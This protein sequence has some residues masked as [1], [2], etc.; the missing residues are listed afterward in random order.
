VPGNDLD[1]HLV[2][3]ASAGTGKTYAIEQLVLR[4][5]TEKGLRL[6][7]ILVVTYTEKATGDLKG[8]L[9]SRLEDT[10]R[11]DSEHRIRLQEALDDF[12]QAHVYTIHGFCQR[13]LQE[14][15]FENRHAFRPQLV[16]DP[17]LLEGCLHEIQ[18]KGWC[19][20]YGA[21]LA[22]VL[23][24]SGY[25]SGRDRAEEWEERA[26]RVAERYRPAAKHMLLPE[27][28]ATW[29]AVLEK[30]DADLR[31]F[32]RQLLQW[33]GPV[34]PHQIEAHPW[35]VGFGRLPGPYTEA[36]RDNVLAHLL[37][38][39]ADPA[40][41]E[42]PLVTFRQ[43]LRRCG[44]FGSFGTNG[45]E[46]L[47]RKMTKDAQAQ[48]PK[49]CPQ[50]REA[51]DELERR[52]GDVDWSVLEQQLAVQT[53]KRLQEQLAAVK[54][55]RGQQSFEDMLT[56]VDQALAPEDARAIALRDVLRK[57]FRYAVVDEFQDTDPVQWNI[58]RRLFV[59]NA[60]DNRLVVVGD[61]KQAIFGF[62][63]ADVEAYLAARD[64]LRDR[65]GA[66]AVLQDTNWRSCSEMLGA[67]NRLFGE[68][69]WFKGSRIEYLAVRPP[70]D[71]PPHRLVTDQTDRPALSLVD[72][73]GPRKLSAARKVYARFVAQEIDR[74]LKAD[75]PTLRIEIKKKP[76]SLR[77]DD[78]CVLVFK[79]PEARPLL[80]ALQAR[81][82]PYT[83][84]K[85]PGLWQSDEAVHLRYLLRAVAHP[86]DRRAFHTALLTRFFR[87][88]PQQL[89]TADE[90]P[91]DHPARELFQRWYGLAEKRQ[92]AELFQ[93]FLEQTGVLFPEAETCDTDRSLA[94]FRHLLQTLEQ[95]AYGR[96][97]DM[98]GVLETFEQ[99]QRGP[100]QADA[101]LKPIE[102]DR[103][104]VK[105]M[106]IHASKGLEF[107]IVFL[108]GGFTSGKLPDVLTYRDDEHKLVFD[109]SCNDGAKD[110]HKEEQDKEDRRLLYVALTRAMFKLYVPRVLAK[111]ERTAGREVRKYS[112]AGPVVEILAPAVVASHLEE[113]GNPH[114]AR[115]AVTPDVPRPATS[116]RRAEEEPRASHLG[117]GSC[118]HASID[119]T[120]APVNLATDLFPVIDVSR[121]RG[122]DISSFSR[123]HR[124][125]AAE[126]P[127]YL[128]RPPRGDDD[129][130]D[131]L[132]KPDTLGGPVFG[133]MVHDVLA[134]I[135]FA[136]VGWARDAADL[137]R[138]RTPAQEL[139]DQVVNRHLP[140]LFSRLPEEQLRK[141]C[142]EQVASLVW[143]GLHTP[144][145]ELGGPLWPIPKTDRLHEL[146][147]HFP[148]QDAASPD[149][150]REDLYLT[151]FMD[152]VFRAGGRY[153]LLDWKTN[154]LPAGYARAEIERSMREC[155]YV[156]QCRLYVQA[157][158]RW[159]KW[160]QGPRFDF[161][162]D[163]G[164]A[165]YLYLRGINA[166]DGGGVFF[167]R[168]TAEDLRL[169]SVL[170]DVTEP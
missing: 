78:I 120:Q 3:E 16:S 67:L 39:L 143:S 27:L 95:A 40:A 9:R 65:S 66:R 88:R 32:V 38:W 135:D 51:V 41:E 130:P 23:E 113:M 37:A 169:E 152:L 166:R 46:L 114:V 62:C 140:R 92:W 48:L 85:E 111:D 2:I 132:E 164:G 76:R 117:N 56:R 157:L 98:L 14:Y 79:R 129:R 159:L 94:N 15:A 163:F 127:S 105:I 10:L 59:E 72:L 50:L 167:H 121:Q 148:C 156:R 31:A 28:M 150:R 64:E 168:P 71:D 103:P 147:F 119:P 7:Q 42:R 55:E 124:R 49:C 86:G 108:A 25:N 29:P 52:R 153:F 146:E 44:E 12:D 70:E 82:I 8:R 36:R 165:Y 53:V 22:T 33:A 131:A 81:D 96:D 84:Y 136:L 80:E 91:P 68:S 104:K 102:T 24:L 87:I 155:D 170:G 47:T 141:A 34:T 35:Y 138:E 43:L 74:L 134:D 30:H 116:K 99:L 123:L 75:G 125:L 4:L 162:R 17:D 58:F 112:H 97:L 107:P 11:A 110:K 26:R 19:R 151:G 73:T 21:L 142:R 139:V 77:A 60:S 137:L 6:D 83:F 93:S 57:R 1:R 13:V 106:T 115:I 144:L 145:A 90:L 45:F 133:D 61:P 128:E 158:A 100:D 122:V 20:E 63:G 89:A 160:S 118:S 154:F 18:R 101:D 5:L 109:L 126:K 149:V 54:S 161:A 69:D